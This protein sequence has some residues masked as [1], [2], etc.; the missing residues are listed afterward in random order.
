MR[1]TVAIPA[2]SNRPLLL[3]RAFSPSWPCHPCMEMVRLQRKSHA[4]ASAMLSCIP[5]DFSTRTHVGASGQSRIP[6]QGP[7]GQRARGGEGVGRSEGWGG[8]G[9]GE[10]VTGTEESIWYQKLAWL[11]RACHGNSSVREQPGGGRLSDDSSDRRL[12]SVA[13]QSAPPS[14]PPSDPSPPP[15]LRSRP[16][17]EIALSR[18]LPPGPWLCR[19][20]AATRPPSPSLLPPPHLIEHDPFHR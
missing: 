5:N 20:S 12:S 18:P 7:S 19:C 14:P 16:L 9:G 8:E 3:W 15:S 6:R 4:S 17:A 13:F 1:V 2:A 11:A 10:Q